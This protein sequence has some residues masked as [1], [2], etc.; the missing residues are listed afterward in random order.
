MEKKKKKDSFI[1]KYIWHILNILSIVLIGLPFVILLINDG[2]VN[3]SF[4]IS[5]IFMGIVIIFMFFEMIYFI[6]RVANNKEIENKAVNCILIYLFSF[7]YIP[8]V[9]V[10]YLYD[11]EK[12]KND[13]IIYLIV[14]IIL[15]V[16][17]CILLFAGTFY[18]ETNHSNSSNRS[19]IVLSDETYTT[20]AEDIKITLPKD[21]TLDEDS[22]YDVLFNANENSI[23]GI[24][25]Y[26]D[27]DQTLEENMQTY[28]SIMNEEIDDLKIIDKNVFNDKTKKILNHTYKYSTNDGRV[29]EDFSIIKFNEKDRFYVL[30]FEL[31]YEEDYDPVYKDVFKEIVK[32]I[33]LNK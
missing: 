3:T 31:C 32:S 17:L 23:I 5:M 26:R 19:E 12:K 16:L 29:V 13:G 30:V 10:K 2:E 20:E 4:L 22:G 27:D 25:F 18:L 21:Y 28:E 9:Y 8:Y 15:Y 11:G 33:E 14:S 24:L 1:K 6:V 7:I